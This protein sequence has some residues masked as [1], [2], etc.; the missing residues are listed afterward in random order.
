[1]AFTRIF[2]GFAAVS[3]LF[4]LY[5]EVERRYFAAPDA[6]PPGPGALIL[7]SGLLTLF[8]GLWFGSL[9]SGGAVLLFLI[10]GALME[11]PPRLRQRPREGLPWKAILA[12]IARITIA[13]VVLGLVL[14]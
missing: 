14:G 11:L 10:L 2:L 8:A 9:G 5:R 13:G 12:G 3:V 4:L 6:V 7:E 1:M